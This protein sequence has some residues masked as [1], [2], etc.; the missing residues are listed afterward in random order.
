MKIVKLLS[1]GLLMCLT[2]IVYSMDYTKL[3]AEAD[4]VCTDGAERWE[5]LAP[6]VTARVT[7]IRARIAEKDR[8][9][10][11]QARNINE[12][13]G[14]IVQLEATLRESGEA[15]STLRLSAL[16]QANRQAELAAERDRLNSLVSNLGEAVSRLLRLQESAGRA[17]AAVNAQMTELE[18]G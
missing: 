10:S 1:L 9:N 13:Q 2:P 7:A 14:S 17:A 6:V 4:K 16:E 11:E 18:R 5:Q 12:L 15:V 8:V 3:L